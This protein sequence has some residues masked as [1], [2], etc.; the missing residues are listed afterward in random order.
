MLR[1]LHN[2]RVEH[3]SPSSAVAVFVGEHDRVTA[4]RVLGMLTWLIEDNELV[5][6]DFSE[7]EFVD[8]SI[9]DVLL[10]SERAARECGH[11]FRLQL[12]TAP[13]VH[14]AFEIS[15]VLE[16]LDCA[17]TREEALRDEVAA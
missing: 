14:R 9:L 6:A 12:A 17:P 15:G 1:P 13:I 8:S 7:A 11:R 4:D 3:P 10:Q 16:V 5:V 2:A